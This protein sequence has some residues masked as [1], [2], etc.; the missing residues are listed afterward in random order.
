MNVFTTFLSAIVVTAC[1]LSFTTINAIPITT[2]TT[3]VPYSLNQVASHSLTN[4][5]FLPPN[6]QLPT[7]SGCDG[8]VKKLITA[9]V[10]FRRNSPS[11]ESI[12]IAQELG[13][14]ENTVKVLITKISFSVCDAIYTMSIQDSQ[15]GE[16]SSS[17]RRKAN[18]VYISARHG[19][20]LFKPLTPSEPE[21]R[22]LEELRGVLDTTAKWY[23][24]IYINSQAYKDLG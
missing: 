4:E 22:Q 9:C 5:S 17:L 16:N 7:L 24:E 8:S 12:A 21:T 23:E 11:I 2:T 10:R 13:R 3:P 14:L 18:R 6:V 1:S 15:N 20:S 19:M